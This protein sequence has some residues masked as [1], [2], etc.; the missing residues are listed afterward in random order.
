MKRRW[1]ALL[2]VVPCGMAAVAWSAVEYKTLWWRTSAVVKPDGAV[3][4]GPNGEVMVR[5]VVPEGEDYTIVR[6]DGTVA[7]PNWPRFSNRW[8]VLPYGETGVFI[9]TCDVK[10]NH[11]PQLERDGSRWSFVPMNSKTAVVIQ[12]SAPFLRPKPLPSCG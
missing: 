10:T 8:F 9:D 12:G 2:A 4:G 5:T 1:I 7:S 6:R 11:D 3:Y